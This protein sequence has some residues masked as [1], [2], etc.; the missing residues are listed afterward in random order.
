MKR[1]LL[2]SILIKAMMIPVACT[3]GN[4]V[5][6]NAGQVVSSGTWRVTL[7]TDSGTN[8]TANFAGFV[9]TFSAGGTVTAIKGSTTQ[10]GT[11]NVNSGSGKFNINLG[12]KDNSNKP[13]GDLSND[14]LIISSTNTEIRLKDNNTASNEFVTFTKN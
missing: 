10:T 6:A 1:I 3:S 12:A 8:E 7:F 2:I 13:L 5:T 11:W 4:A 14:W 9:F